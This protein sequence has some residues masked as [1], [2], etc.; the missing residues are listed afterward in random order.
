M[1]SEKLALKTV[2]NRAVTSTHQEL[3]PALAA[4][5][6][7]ESWDC[8]AKALDAQAATRMYRKRSTSYDQVCE[9]G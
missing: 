5:A 7:Q 6:C 9:Q 2:E 8:P 1:K 3:P 4:P